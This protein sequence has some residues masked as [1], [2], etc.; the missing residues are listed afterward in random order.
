MYTV[1]EN[2]LSVPLCIVVGVNVSVNTSYTIKVQQ[3]N[4]SQPDGR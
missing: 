2:D 3:N 1:P 4:Q